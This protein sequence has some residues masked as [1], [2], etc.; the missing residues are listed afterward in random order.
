MALLYCNKKNAQN[1]EAL[2]RSQAVIEFSADGLIITANQNFLEAT[3]Y[4]LA[5]IQNKHHRMFLPEHEQFS[6]SYTLFW[7]ALGKGEFQSGEYRRITKMRRTLWLQATYNP[8]MDKNGKVTRIIKFASD[9]TA[10]KI[11]TIDYESQL[12]A[13][14]RSQAVIQFKLDGTILT[15]NENFLNAVGYSL[16]EIQGK[17]HSM[18]VCPEDR[19]T[20]EYKTFWAK[21][22]EGDFQTAVYKRIGKGGKEI[23]I[24]ATYNPIYDLEGKPCKVVKYATDITSRIVERQRRLEAQSAINQSLVAITQSIDETSAE[25]DNAARASAVTTQN[26]ETVAAGAEQL[27]ASITDISQQVNQALNITKKA[28]EHTG[29]TT[30]IASG[31]VECARKIGDI[32][33]MINSIASQTNLL[34]LNATIE[35]ARAGESGRGFAVVASEVKNLAMQTARATDDISAQ[36]VEVQSSSGQVVEAINEIAKIIETIDVFSSGIAAAV[37]EQSQVTHSMSSTM[38]HAADSVKEISSRMAVIADTASHT[39][40]AV[41]KVQEMAQAVA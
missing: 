33:E 10:H 31:L 1:M 23:W 4:S 8:I 9:I 28:V 34:A 24:Q 27:V 30:N 29:K 36:I 3:G 15:A 32:V 2:H 39:N 19:H 7:K 13:I 25:V 41:Q 16:D 26:V 35:A 20:A 38:L 14:S 40:Q 18:F 11:R 17:H 37:E 6:E 22:A 12:Q 21:L 5:E